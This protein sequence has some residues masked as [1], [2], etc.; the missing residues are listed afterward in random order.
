MS[1]LSGDLLSSAYL[2]SEA[3][4]RGL[5]TQPRGDAW[6]RGLLAWWRRSNG[7]LGPASAPQSVLDIGARPL[8]NLLE[9]R[10]AYIE[11]HP[12]GHAARLMHES[13]PVA[14]LV[15]PPWGTSPATA[16][17]HAVRS[18]LVAQVPWA[19]VLQVRAL[20]SWMPRGRGPNAIWPSS[21]PRLAAILA[22]C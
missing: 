9:L 19:V 2:D 6:A 4:G 14:T 13:E 17:R 1:G 18:T 7:A 3:V 11:R 20:R 15:C 21:S 22:R 12:W 10:V 8:L 16:W 5:V